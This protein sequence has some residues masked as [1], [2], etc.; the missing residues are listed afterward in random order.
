MTAGAEDF[1]MGFTCPDGVERHGPLSV[2]WSTPFESVLPN[3]CFPVYRGQRNWT[4][5][6]WSA[7]CAG[8][9]GYESWLERDHVM[10]LDFDPDVV[11]MASQ[12]FTLSWRSPD[13]VRMQHTPDY[14]VRRADGTGL[15]VDVRPDH[16]IEPRDTV[17]FLATAAA[18]ATVGWDFRRAGTPD[19][20][21]MANVR[22]LAG[23][24]HLRVHRPAVAARLTEVFASGAGLLAGAGQVGDPIAVLPVLFHLLW[25][26]E[27]VA[28]LRSRPL[29]AD[30][31]V[32]LTADCREGGWYADASAASASG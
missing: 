29:A 31:H 6:Y 8:H 22:W 24:R 3:R 10:L 32:R 13:G 23:Y 7:T 28:D 30:T 25:K 5:W 15:V 21:L 1:W 20:V 11:G 19:A 4:G 27:L 2:L 9:I 17:K 16:R 12:P 26:Q 18:C 14:F